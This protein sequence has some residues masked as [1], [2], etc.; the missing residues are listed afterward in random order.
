MG[1]LIDFK[2]RKV[3]EQPIPAN[4]TAT[5]TP[6]PVAA[7]MNAKFTIWLEKA[8]MQATRLWVE[9]TAEK[10]RVAEFVMAGRP[11]DANDIVGFVNWITDVFSRKEGSK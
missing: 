7:I 8:S 2:T 10:V 3:I 4:V 1:I 11:I 9:N 6:T 5:M